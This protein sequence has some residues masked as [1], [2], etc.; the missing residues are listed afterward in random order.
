MG[1][2]GDEAWGNAENETLG[3]LWLYG[4]YKVFLAVGIDFEEVVGDFYVFA[5]EDFFGE[6]FFH[7]ILKRDTGV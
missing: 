1:E 2:C 3:I 5:G 7:N 6:D 4:V